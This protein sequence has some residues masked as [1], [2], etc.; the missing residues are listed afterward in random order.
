MP[1]HVEQDLVVTGP[2][3]TLQEFIK[4]AEE[5]EDVFSTPEKVKILS[6]NKFIPYPE[7]FQKLDDAAEEAHEKGDYAVKDGFNSGGYQWCIQNWGTK[8]GIYDAT[9][10][11]Q[12]LI[13]KKGKIKY[14]SQ[15]AWSPPLP[16][17]DAMSK[18]FPDLK[19]DM[20]YYER[21]MA[22]KGHYVVQNGEVL[23]N[24]ESAYHGHRGG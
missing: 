2:V 22:F 19:F 23:T 4:F 18:K 13:G 8:W 20:K 11:S 17:V 21:G 3:A 7:E 10:V 16:V 9:I 14:T 12:K 6:A 15:S 1:N 5:E 24:E